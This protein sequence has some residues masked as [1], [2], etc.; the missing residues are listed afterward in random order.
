MTC[1]RHSR[2]VEAGPLS[3]GYLEQVGSRNT[4]YRF[5]GGREGLGVLCICIQAF[6][7]V[8]S[9]Q[10]DPPVPQALAASLGPD[11]S[12]RHRPCP[13]PDSIHPTNARIDCARA[14]S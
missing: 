11:P 10:L 14:H 8:R 9:C 3:L 13:G 2:E 7:E 12:S 1:W 5:P 4:L 6:P